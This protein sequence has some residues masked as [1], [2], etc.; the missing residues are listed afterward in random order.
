MFNIYKIEFDPQNIFSYSK[1]II[2]WYFYVYVNESNLEEFKML[3]PRLIRMIIMLTRKTIDCENAYILLMQL[4]Q[5]CKKLTSVFIPKMKIELL[6]KFNKFIKE[7][8]IKHAAIKFVKK[9][10]DNYEKE[11][12]ERKIGLKN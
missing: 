1:Y 11:T 10:R 8:Y 5:F 9:T 12:D 6:D 3:I 4:C 2:D 7:Q